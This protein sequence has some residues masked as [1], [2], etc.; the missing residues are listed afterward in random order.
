MIPGANRVKKQEGVGHGLASK[1]RISKPIK[2]NK[3]AKT[4]FRSHHGK[5]GSH[6]S[7]DCYSLKNRAE[8]SME[9]KTIVTS[10]TNHGFKGHACKKDEPRRVLA[11]SKVEKQEDNQIDKATAEVEAI[12]EDLSYDCKYPNKNNDK[13]Y[14][15]NSALNLL[16]PIFIEN[17]KLISLIDTGSDASFI[18]VISLTKKLKI[19]KVIKI[20]AVALFKDSQ[21]FWNIHP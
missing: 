16:T 5:N 21:N 1:H 18:D 8:K 13:E 7:K 10:A 4:F 9:K 20:T 6:N 14:S 12:M 2:A 11:V 17:V 3:S 19:N 15:D